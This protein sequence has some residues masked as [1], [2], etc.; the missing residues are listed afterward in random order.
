M[1]PLRVVRS[2]GPVWYADTVLGSRRRFHDHAI[3]RAAEIVSPD[4]IERDCR[5]TLAEYERAGI[6]EY[7]IIDE[8]RDEARFY[9]LGTDGRYGRAA[10][11]DDDIYTSTVLMGLRLRVDWLWRGPLLTLDE[12]R[13]DLPA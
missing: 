5:D 13:A 7:W 12:A 8:L 3:E 4:S 2:A 6:P 9:V 1:A 11:S 10:V